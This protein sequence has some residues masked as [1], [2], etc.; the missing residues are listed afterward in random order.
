MAANTTTADA[1][2][3]ALQAALNAATAAALQVWDRDEHQ[4][5]GSCGNAMLEFD[6]RSTV[7]KV[8]EQMGLTYRSGRE[9]WLNLPL[10]AGVRSQNADIPQEQKRAFRAA[11]E[12]A[13]YGKAVKRFWTYTD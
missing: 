8:A 1:A 2:R 9:L 6:A 13:G 11:L 3:A 12:A 7:A 10:P 4:D 5:R